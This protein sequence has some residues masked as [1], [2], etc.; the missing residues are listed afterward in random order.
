MEF[1]DIIDLDIDSSVANTGLLNKHLSNATLGNS[2]SS[3]EPVL[4]SA[5]K[6]LKPDAPDASSS[7]RSSNKLTNIMLE[8]APSQ[9]MSF[10]VSS[11]VKKF[12]VA[13]D[14]MAMPVETIAR[15]LQKEPP[16]SPRDYSDYAKQAYPYFEND[17]QDDFGNTILTG[18]FTDWKEDAAPSAVNDAQ[19][20]EPAPESTL[21]FKNDDGMV[22]M[23][24]ARE[25][26]SHPNP[27]RLLACKAAPKR[28]RHL[29]DR[30]APA[31]LEPILEQPGL[32]IE[33]EEPAEEPAKEPA[34]LPSGPAEDEANTAEPALKKFKGVKI[35]PGMNAQEVNKI[36]NE[37]LERKRANSRR[38]H[39]KF[40]SKGV[41]KGSP[42]EHED[43]PN[44]DE[45]APPV[46]DADALPSAA[47]LNDVRW[48]FVRKFL[49]E[50]PNA[51]IK[52]AHREWMHSSER[53]A[54]Q[55]GRQ[56]L[57]I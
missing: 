18:P 6:K 19:H 10:Q 23:E 30:L 25:E 7:S 15:P 28:S 56:G 26:A 33:E 21:T 4:S 12:M 27:V 14:I 57:Q 11:D 49:A 8:G 5:S 20:V 45:E 1:S 22:P 53:A 52:D 54:F 36:K 43:V 41:L 44:A 2:Q 55:A 48:T 3:S 39:A 46:P 16:L 37:R 50:T 42:E 47:T 17:S 29:N 13:K 40:E 24:P 35:T 34:E 38:W 9:V 31:D 32:E 51:T